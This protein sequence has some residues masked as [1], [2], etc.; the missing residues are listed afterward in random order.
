MRLE[1]RCFV[2]VLEPID[3]LRRDRCIDDHLVELG[4]E[5]LRD[6]FV[7]DNRAEQALH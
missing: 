5:V 6:F 7:R 1:V 4:A 3:D 2:R